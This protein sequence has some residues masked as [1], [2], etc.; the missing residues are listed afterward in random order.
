MS[1]CSTLKDINKMESLNDEMPNMEPSCGSLEEQGQVM[2][3]Y[4]VSLDI[5]PQQC[6]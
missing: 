5:G 4:C 1:I 2:P 6:S 3:H